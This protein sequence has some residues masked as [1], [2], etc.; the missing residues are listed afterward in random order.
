MR[1]IT[2]AVVIGSGVMGAGIGAHLANA[3]IQV[4]LLDIVPGGLNSPADHETR[5]SIA[6]QA[7]ERLARARTPIFYSAHHAELVRAGNLED[8]F[9]RVAHADWIIEAI[10]E[11]LDIKQSLLQRISKTSKPQAIVTTNTSGLSIN[12][13]A[14]NLPFEF[15]GRFLG[16]H[17]FNPPWIMKLL[18]LIPGKDTL[19]EVVD[20]LKDFATR[21]LGKGVVAARDTPGFIAN[22]IGTCALFGGIRAMVDLDMTVEEVDA[23][24]GPP[25]GRP[26]TATLRTNDLAGLDL[27]LL[28]SENNR[29]A[30]HGADDQAAFALP[31]LVS[32]MVKK[33]IRGDKSG[34]GF[35]KKVN[36]DGKKEVLVFDYHSMEYRPQK[37]VRF[38]SLVLAAQKRDIREKLATVVFADDP[39]GRL[40]YRLLKEMI[41]YAA[42][43]AMEIAHSLPDIDRAMKWGFN[44]AL[45]PF[46]TW[47][48]LGVSRMAERL[49]D[50]K[51]PVPGIVQKLLAS[52]RTSFYSESEG[53]PWCFD[54]FTGETAPVPANP[55]VI[56]LKDIKHQRGIVK[57]GK[58]SSLVDLGD[59][60]AC[61]EFHGKND[62]AGEDLA[63]MILFSV[64]EIEKNWNGLVIGHQSK[65]FCV[66][67]NLKRFLGRIEANDLASIEKEI[68]DVQQAF[69]RLK[70]CGKPVVAAPHGVAYGGGAEIILSS[71]RVRAMVDLS[72]GLV[73]PQVGLVPAAGGVKEMTLRCTENIPEDVEADPLPFL[74][75]TH[76]RLCMAAA[77]ANAHQA[78]AAG[79]LRSTDQISM[80]REGL[81]R[82]AKDMVLHM[83]NMGYFPP[84]PKK[85]R[86]TGS[87]GYAALKASV[88]TMRAKGVLSDYSAH[89]GE[90]LAYIM[91]GGNL[92]DKSLVDEQRLMDLEL[93]VFMELVRDSR[94]VDR[95]RHMLEKGKPLFN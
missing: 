33:D 92:P 50:E 60:V 95:I 39:A 34:Q 68:K 76:Q 71:P 67:A 61:L 90:K 64:E 40:A 4:D 79:F 57:E 22:R 32:E 11:R 27:A 83:K 74:Q 13:M 72:I 86:V 85:I 7:R 47:D 19:P 58:D 91:T 21:I 16:A 80:N 89:I 14:S 37:P 28:V 75:K 94:T 73:E 69:T 42:D 2:K 59:G 18:E 66:G 12:E 3:G 81:L 23:V 25:L 78:R 20:F 24:T 6:L 62:V 29:K 17:F 36:N 30:L 77:F 26:K 88:E 5:S 15:R 63:E 65:N 82:E 45:G 49:A 93:E 35:Y 56:V 84:A 46:E 70:H 1:S 48:A 9:E 38:E 52:G 51:Q 54:P 10:V 8:D 31:E 55:R 87:S 41:V 53:R 44:W 43:H